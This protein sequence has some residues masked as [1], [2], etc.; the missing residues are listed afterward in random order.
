MLLGRQINLDKAR[1]LSFMDDHEGMMRE[2]LKQ[3][4]GEAEF[5]KLKGFQ[6]RALADAVG[7]NVE[8]LSRMARTRETAAGGME[9]AKTTEEKSLGVQEK[10]L[11]NLEEMAGVA[12]D[13][14]QQ[15]KKT[16]DGITEAAGG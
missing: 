13:S 7:V 2:I 10:M 5:E 12:K 6:R 9:V 4:G 11:V 14:Y 16:A 15:Q 8:E 1:Q 3:G